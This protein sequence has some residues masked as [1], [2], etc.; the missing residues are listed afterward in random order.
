MTRYFFDYTSRDRSLYDYQGEEFL[1]SSAAY[2]FASASAQ[3]LKNSLASDWGGWSI[4]VRDAIG[5][6]LFSLPIS[7]G[8]RIAA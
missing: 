6:K 1:S 5:Q 2:E 8:N 3:S 7:L 4:E